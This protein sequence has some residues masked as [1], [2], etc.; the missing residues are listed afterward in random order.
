MQFEETAVSAYNGRVRLYYDR[1]FTELK[2]EGRLNDGSAVE[3]G[4]EF[5]ENGRNKYAGNYEE[6]VYSG[7]GILYLEDGTV[8]YRGMLSLIHI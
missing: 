7:S 6:G 2:F 1:E 8:L 4:E 5:W 3:Y